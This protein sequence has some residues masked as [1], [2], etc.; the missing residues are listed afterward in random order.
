MILPKLH[1]CVCCQGMKTQVPALAEDS[2]GRRV[3]DPAFGELVQWKE[4]VAADHDL[5]FPVLRSFKNG[6]HQ[7]LP[8]GLHARV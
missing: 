6:P 3:G 4:G 2:G 8:S 1:S 7:S 5:S